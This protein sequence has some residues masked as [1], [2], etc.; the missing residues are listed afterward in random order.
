MKTIW[1]YEVKTTDWFIIT[2]PVGS[3][4]L[5]VQI[6]EKTGN[7]CVWVLLESE[8]P[9][10]E[11]FFEVFGT[12]NPINSDMGVDREYIGTY[13]KEGFVWHLFERF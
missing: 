7:P 10:E 4:I 5:T 8:M 9:D 3:D 6:D 11:R 2:M 12:G 1:K 13:Q